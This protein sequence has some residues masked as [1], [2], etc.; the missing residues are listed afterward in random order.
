MMHYKLLSCPSVFEG[1]LLFVY[2]CICG[3]LS[4]YLCWGAC[5]TGRETDASH[6]LV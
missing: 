1:Q 5:R 6:I 2:M 4:L 3:I